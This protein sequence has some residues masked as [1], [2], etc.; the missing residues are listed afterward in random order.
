M[1]MTMA[2]ELN[3]VAQKALGIFLDVKNVSTVSNI[4]ALVPSPSTRDQSYLPI[5][6]KVDQ[7]GILINRLYLVHN[8]IR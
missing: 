4:A 6:T 3:H 2:T 1:E 5:C 7:F 8:F